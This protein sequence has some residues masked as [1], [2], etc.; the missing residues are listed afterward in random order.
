MSVFTTER[1]HAQLCAMIAS[2]QWGCD[3]TLFF[4]FS[5]CASIFSRIFFGEKQLKYP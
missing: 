5:V 1:K 4:S 3:R 2:R